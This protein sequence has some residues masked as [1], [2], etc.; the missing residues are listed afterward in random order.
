M[1]NRSIVRVAVV[2]AAQVAAVLLLAAL[3][4]GLS[5][6]SGDT[7]GAAVYDVAMWGLVPLIGLGC[8]WAAARLGAPYGIAWIAPPLCQVAAHWLMAGVLPASPGM[9]M[10]TL[11]LGALGAAAG[12]EQNVRAARTHKGKHR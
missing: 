12:H 4:I 6:A 10:V 11:L 8:A 9:P 3:L 7:V 5:L 2:L 1:K